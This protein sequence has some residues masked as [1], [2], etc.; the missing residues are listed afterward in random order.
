V[1][2]KIE[3]VNDAII[4]ARDLAN[5]QKGVDY[6][7]SFSN[8]YRKLLAKKKRLTKL[9]NY[10]VY[11]TS[12]SRAT[13]FCAPI[14]ATSYGL[15]TLANTVRNSSLLT[16]ASDNLVNTL[17]SSTLWIGSAVFLS[18]E[19]GR[20]I[21]GM[22]KKDGITIKR[23]FKNI[24]MYVV[25]Q[26][27][28]VGGAAIGAAVGAVIGSLFLP[29]WGTIIGK[30]IGGLAGGYLAANKAKEIWVNNFEKEIDILGKDKCM[31][32]GYK[33]ALDYLNVSESSPRADID[34]QRKFL[35]V[36]CHPDKNNNNPE[37]NEKF[38]Q[39]QLAFSIIEQTRMEKGTWS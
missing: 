35:M 36:H 38:I 10:G 23:A 17:S 19:I 25:T 1:Q 27:S 8:F 28:G 9:E 34:R 15:P 7:V 4:M 39:I 26:G 11:I 3:E 20:N 24:A 2:V 14:F 37:S 13:E 21:H 12:M 31:N 5:Q 18:I 22:F 16:V 30:V 29:G 6:F 32:E 33:N